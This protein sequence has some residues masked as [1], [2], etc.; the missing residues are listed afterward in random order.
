M[1]RVAVSTDGTELSPGEVLDGRYRLVARLG[2]GGFGDVW[3]AEELLPSGA[4]FRE[5][6]LKL[7]T[8]VTDETFWA[9]EARLLASFR[10][11][12]L[13]TIYAAGRL[14]LGRAVSGLPEVVPYVAME[15]LVGGSLAD[16]TRARGPVPYRR[17]LA[18]VRD[19]A[20]ALDVIHRA[21]VVH[22]D[23]KPANLF[24]T[25]DGVLKVLDFGIA[26]RAGAPEV[27]TRSLELQPSGAPLAELGTAEFVAVQDAF[28][29]TQAVSSGNTERAVVGTPGFMAPEVF[30]RGELSPATDAYALAATFVLLTTGRLPHEV[31]GEPASDEPSVVS[32]WWAELRQATVSGR[33]RDLAADPARLPA[34]VVALA[35]RLL[36]VDPASRG[37]PTGG[38]FAQLDAVWER[39]YG[40]PSPLFCGL[41]PFGFERQ[42]WLFGRDEDLARLGR[43]LLVGPA[44][45]V[46]GP[47]GTGLTSL[48]LAGLVP[49]LARASADGKDDWEPLRIDASD[50]PD[51]ALAEALGARDASLRSAS[52]AQLFAHAAASPVGLALVLDPAPPEAA[53][54]AATTRLQGLLA[55]LIEERP[56]GLRLVVVAH[57]DA[58]EALLEGPLGP[59]LRPFFH[60]AAAPAP[61][62]AEAL[63]LAPLALVGRTVASPELIVTDIARE[64]REEGRR[65]PYVAVALARFF[66]EGVA[67]GARWRELG[68]VAGL[69]AAEAETA[70]LGLAQ[71]DRNLA[72]KLLVR[73]SSA[74]GDPVACSEEALVEGL[75]DDAWE[76]ELGPASEVLSAARGGS[77]REARRARLR[78]ILGRLE[79][80]AVLRRHAGLVRVGHPALLKTAPRLVSA[81]LAAMDRLVF[82][83]ALREAA[84][85]WERAGARVDL[86]WRGKL[87]GD[88]ALERRWLAGLLSPKEQGFIDESRRKERLRFGLRAALVFALAAAVGLFALA[89][90]AY[91]E[92]QR[93]A[94]QRRVEAEA[95]AYVAT[96][97]ARARHSDDPY[98]RGAWIVEAMERGSRDGALS[99]ELL[100]ALREQPAARFL[101]LAKLRSVSM[102]WGDRWA[103]GQSGGADLVLADLAPPQKAGVNDDA[104][105]DASFDELRRAGLLRPVAHLLRP[106]AEP[107]AEVVPLAFDTAFAS[108]SVSGEVRLFRLRENGEVSLAAVLPMVCRGA[109]V[110][111]ARAPVLACGGEEGVLALD[112]RNLRDGRG[113]ER[114]AGVASVLGLSADGA[115]VAT[116]FGAKLRLWERAGGTQHE[117]ATQAPV[118]L[119]RFHPTRP[120]LALVEPGLVEVLPIGA[121][122]TRIRVLP[123]DEG[124]TDARWSRDGEFLA[125]CGQEQSVIQL[126][127]FSEGQGR[128]PSRGPRPA[129]ADGSGEDPCHPARRE[130]AP[131]PLREPSDVPPWAAGRGDFLGG[132][133]LPDGRLLGRELVL[134]SPR[135]PQGSGS[136]LA[137]SGRDMAGALEGHKADDSVVA[138]LR[139]GPE[140]VVFQV[141]NEIR[142]YRARDG[143][144]EQAR[145][146]NLLGACPDGRLLAWNAA[147]ETYAVIDARTGGVVASPPREPGLVLG[148]DSTCHSLFTQRLDGT[149]LA[150]SLADGGAPRVLAVADGLVH[151]VK[152]SPARDGHEAGLWLALSSGAILRL[153]D[154]GALWLFAYAEPRATALGD[155]PRAGELVYADASGIVVADG[156]GHTRRYLDG[157]SGAV[158]TD[159]AALPGGDAILLASSARLAVLELASGDLVASMPADGRGRLSLWDDGGSV[160]AWSFDRAGGARGLIVPVSRE[161]ASAAAMSLSNVWIR[162]GSLELR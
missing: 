153:E 50:A 87:L 127:P 158:F 160:L 102:P 12:S 22:L 99:L 1:A 54:E 138:V 44:L 95:A 111:A 93:D 156:S 161:Q 128:A 162:G 105:V 155:G 34:G 41:A 126:A 73:L 116:V 154:S 59:L 133:E 112:L 18:W 134:V 141:G 100:R 7:L 148:V 51:D 66:R 27:H 74:E 65:L 62:S 123:S 53:P 75:A 86:L 82:R 61:T 28:A 55:A 136:K 118:V 48:A 40:A 139:Q 119:A 131:R 114:L 88:F 103:L 122:E 149:L 104:P 117:V 14:P 81:R 78:M 92:G 42:G 49:L 38:L 125:V 121:P 150:H 90:S 157:G 11:P 56:K 80:S 58:A 30:E 152:R 21:G 120:V 129:A 68:G 46:A 96:V 76:L 97:V 70:L 107:I 10:H 13:V 25:D 8:T 84:S 39:P 2:R 45:V 85:G 23:L 15:L 24:L 19:A 67:D 3:R 57:E 113:P 17:A 16:R 47:R 77:Q 159:L 63:V 101:T 145:K 43:A 143:Q 69:V 89:R 106:H 109:L 115:V 83:D 132:Y 52:D 94:E 142:F 135:D 4:S 37:A 108:R 36:D 140:Q 110:A 60:F 124:P 137:F 144:R 64:L 26:R 71:E 31:P 130:G 146:G 98:V 9:E 33:L 151:E 5:V 72:E 35:R 20:A 147:G 6:A 79:A 91:E 32:A 29:R